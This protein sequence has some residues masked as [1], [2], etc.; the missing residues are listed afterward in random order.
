MATREKPKVISL[1]YAV[2]YILESD[3]SDIDSSVGGLSSAEEE[4]LDDDLLG[5]G[6]NADEK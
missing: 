1:E 4:R 5:Y 3:D 2:N 6:S